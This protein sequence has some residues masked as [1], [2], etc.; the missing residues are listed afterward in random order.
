MKLK[1]GTYVIFRGVSVKLLHD[2][3]VEALEG[4]EDCLDEVMSYHREDEAR[5]E[6]M[7]LED[8]SE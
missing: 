6:L 3:Q 7:R 2:V 4:L 8:E 1:Q 5:Q